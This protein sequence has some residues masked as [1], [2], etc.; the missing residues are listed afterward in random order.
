MGVQKGWD[1][2]D[3]SEK[4]HGGKALENK[5]RDKIVAIDVAQWQ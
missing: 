4:V 2:V 3:S 5:L 1:L